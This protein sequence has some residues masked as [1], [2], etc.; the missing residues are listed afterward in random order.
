IEPSAVVRKGRVAPGRMFLVDTE[1]GRIIG[2]DEIKAEVAS[3]QPWEDWVRQN[4][5]DL[6]SLPERE[7]VRHTSESILQRQRIFGYTSEE[8]RILVGPMAQTGAEPLG[9]M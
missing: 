6:E 4:L 9:A 3:A 2:D 8:L 7:H 1:Q 5:L